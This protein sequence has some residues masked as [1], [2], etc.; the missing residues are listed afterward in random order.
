M[1]AIGQ[2]QASKDFEKLKNR[3]APSVRL[4]VSVESGILNLDISTDDMSEDE[5]LDLL[6]SYRKKKKFFR[7][8]LELKIAVTVLPI[9][10]IG[11]I[12]FFH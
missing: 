12:C 2:V 1:M 11:I 9:V 10:F 8:K 7:L 5:L 6:E 4:G 3:R